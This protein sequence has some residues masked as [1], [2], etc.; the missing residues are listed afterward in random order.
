MQKR[1][2]QKA[3]KQAQR[4]AKQEELKQMPEEERKA[5]REASHVRAALA[6]CSWPTLSTLGTDIAAPPSR[7]QLAGVRN[8]T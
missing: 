5:R 1:K 6:A 3:K 4:Q 7:Q 2:E 8:L